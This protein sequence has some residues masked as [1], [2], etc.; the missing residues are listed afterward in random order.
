MKLRT[1]I[2][3][4]VLITMSMVF[5]LW[6]DKIPFLSSSIVQ[7]SLW[8][9][10]V[11]GDILV[12]IRLEREQFYLDKKEK[13]AEKKSLEQAIKNLQEKKEKIKHELQ[14][15]Q[16]NLDKVNASIVAFP[17]PDIAKIEERYNK[18]IMQENARYEKQK[19]ADQKLYSE[20]IHLI[21]QTHEDKIRWNM[22]KN[23]TNMQDAESLLMTNKKNALQSLTNAQIEHLEKHEENIESL[24]EDKQ[25]DIQKAKVENNELL[26]PLIQNKNTLAEKK[27]NM[28]TDLEG[29]MAEESR[30]MI[31]LEKLTQSIHAIEDDIAVLDYKII[32]LEEDILK[33]ITL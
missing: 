29:I 32:M 10:D 23:T 24:D 13:T 11:P 14:T 30:S 19:I 3:G 28:Q 2:I 17:W 4:L 33:S 7:A 6:S 31:E 9:S 15:L 26:L 21:E 20:T 12:N 22:E 18:E 5:V 1:K 25:Q 27:T 8:S 16:E